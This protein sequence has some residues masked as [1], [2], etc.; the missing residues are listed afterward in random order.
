[1]KKIFPVLFVL[2]VFAACN[3]DGG[4]TDTSG[5]DSSP[6]GRAPDNSAATN[7]SIADTLTGD[8]AIDSLQGNSSDS[9][10]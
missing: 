5:F 2:F 1:M 7:P 8:I 3:N 6:M 10:R 4:D 9:L